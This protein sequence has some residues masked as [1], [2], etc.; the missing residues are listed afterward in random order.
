[1]ANEHWYAVQQDTTDAWDYGSYDLAEAIRMANDDQ[2]DIIAVI[3]EGYDTLCVKELHRGEDFDYTANYVVICDTDRALTETT[4]FETEQEAIAYANR[5]FDRMSE[6]DKKHTVAYYVIKS[7]DP[8][9]ASECHT[10]GDL[11]KDYLAD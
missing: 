3:E 1:M 8:N 9:P 5:D 11:I 7:N 2:A 10:D 6:Y 4:D